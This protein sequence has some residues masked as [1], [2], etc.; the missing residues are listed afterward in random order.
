VT[1]DIEITGFAPDARTS[2]TAV[3]TAEEAWTAARAAEARDPCVLLV[4]RR[5]GN[6]SHGDFH[7]WL[8]GDRAL[9]RLDEHRE[10]RAMDPAR[11]AS[12]EMGDTWFRDSD[13]TPFP[14]Q[15]A[16]AVSRSQAMDAL[17]FWLKA[18]QMLPGL[19]WT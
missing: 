16:E 12:A 1:Y 9:V 7:V 18:G 2:R 8:A 5:S 14:A 3:S 11:V 13:G 19:T 4:G 17:A 6:V 15:D 10:W